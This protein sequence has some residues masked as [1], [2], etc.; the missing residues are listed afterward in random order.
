MSAHRLEANHELHI[1]LN[2][3]FSSQVGYYLCTFTTLNVAMYNIY[4]N[5]KPS[6]GYELI[7]QSMPEPYAQ[8]VAI[9]N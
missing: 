8:H 4:F 1:Y 6:Q 7:S 9:D 5:P 2:I 3:S